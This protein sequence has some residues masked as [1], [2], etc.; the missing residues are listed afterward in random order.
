[1]IFGIG[2]DTIE[3]ARIARSVEQYG[4]QFLNRIFC[5]E[6]IRYS[7]WMPRTAEH[8]AA[9]FAAKE[10]FAKA[11]GTGV[12]R[13]FSWNKVCVLKER[14]G[15]PYIELRGRMVERASSIVAQPFTVQ[16]SLTHTRELAEAMVVI[17]TS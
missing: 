4:E 2:I 1:M 7:Q 14:S 5:E 10:A 12:R 8:F 3:V 11:L 9:R 6:E 17:E 13:G 15:R 16:L